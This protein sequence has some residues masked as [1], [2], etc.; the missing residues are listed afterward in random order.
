[1]AVTTVVAHLGAGGVGS[2]SKKTKYGFE[3]NLFF[4][5]IARATL[6]SH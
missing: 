5:I 4:R 1:M 2:A 6:W 3:R